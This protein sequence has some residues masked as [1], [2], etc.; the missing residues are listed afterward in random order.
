MYENKT[1]ENILS[2]M[3]S[4]V[5]ENYPEL[6]TRVG[7]VIY[8]ALAPIALELE[9]AYH[10]MDMIIDETFMATASK[11]Y[12]ALH[13]EQVGLELNDATN[14]NLEAEFD[15]DVAIGSRFNSGDYNYS[16][17]Y[18][19]SDPTETEQYYKFC[20]ICETLGSEP[21][22]HLGTLTPITYVPNLTHAELTSILIYGE[23]EEDTEVFRERLQNHVKNPPIN[24]NVAQY[25]EW[26]NE[27]DGVGGYKTIPCWNGVN[28]V[29]L[30][31]LNSENKKASDDLISKTQ[32]YFD[33]PTSA[34]NDDTSDS[35]YPQGRGMGNGQA[36][37]GSIVTVDTVTEIPVVVNCKV[38]LKDGYT[39]PAGLEDAVNEY[40]E[41]LV[42]NKSTVAYM[43]ISAVIYN[44][45]C[46]D[47][48]V[49]LSITV[50]GS[51]MDTSA[52][53]FIDS[54]A[55][56]STEIPVLD[57]ENSVWSVQ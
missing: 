19:I 29:K 37:I 34:I 17:F 39:S 18:K 53:T 24:G 5:S 40:I 22:S 26:L 2:D 47:E 27:C 28:T 30:L 8:T 21:N 6:D 42:F 14:A 33:P 32:T 57:T 52:T 23:D 20:L 50:K 25:D 44:T 49:S 35:T 1:F 48:V 51:V 43:P 15:T 16:V 10:E 12:L 31:I 13:G 56:G 7:S 4:Y 9:T 11:E 55:L 54:V 41:S 46:V 3:L 45:D 36:P 38:T